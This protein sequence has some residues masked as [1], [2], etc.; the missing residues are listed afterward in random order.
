MGNSL[1]CFPVLTLSE[2]TS[3]TLVP[4]AGMAPPITSAGPYQFHDTRSALFPSYLFLVRG[5]IVSS[6]VRLVLRVIL[7]IVSLVFCSSTV[8]TDRLQLLLRLSRRRCNASRTVSVRD[9][10]PFLHRVV[11]GVVPLSGVRLCRT[12]D[13]Q[14]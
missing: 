6:R 4:E 8:I 1:S 7:I 11:V 12:H 14:S 5:I 2:V 10:D 13:L 9:R 3:P